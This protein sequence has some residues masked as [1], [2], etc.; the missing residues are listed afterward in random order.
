MRRVAVIGAGVFGS[1]IATQ[2]ARHDL[3]VDLFDKEQ[4]ILMGATPKSV[5]RLHLGFHY[6]RDLGTAIQS[7][8]GYVNFLERFPNSVDFNFTN[9]YALAKEGSRVTQSDFLDFVKAAGINMSEVPKDILTDSGFS[10]SKVQAIYL[11]KEGVIDVSLLRT[12]FL[13]EMDELRVT[14][15]LNNEIVSVR[16]ASGKWVTQD[17]NMVEREYDFIVRATYGHDRI[18]ISP[19]E[20]TESRKYEFHKTL[21]LEAEIDIPRTGMTIIDGDFLTVLPKAGHNTHLLYAP[22]PSVMGRFTGH[23]Y[24]VTWDKI[25]NDLIDSAEIALVNRYKEW[26]T[27]SDE[28]VI[29]ERLVTVRAIDSDVKET[30][31][32]ISH[33]RMQSERFIDVRSGKID[34]CVEI[35]LEVV[36]RITTSI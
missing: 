35:A 28:V 22:V 34:H 30:D 11:N 9:Y 21:V 24:P 15:F 19:E 26:F 10:S 27:N 13:K 32:R 36:N 18:I 23:E 8:K 4:D 25:H 33:L 1:E 29:K 7:R 31:R 16:K 12:Q 5:L 3:K 14:K 6:P 20:G 2:I 17:H